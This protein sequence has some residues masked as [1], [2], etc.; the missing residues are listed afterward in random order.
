GRVILATGYLADVVEGALG[1][2]FGGMDLVYSRERAPL[3]T[4][5]AIRGALVHVRAPRIFVLN[6][7]SY[8]RFDLDRLERVHTRAGADATLWL[9]ERSG[10]DRFGS[11]GLG[12]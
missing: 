11:V 12:R 10:G 2:R 7:D 8:C 3:G 5:G 6:G 4:A 9:V 1:S